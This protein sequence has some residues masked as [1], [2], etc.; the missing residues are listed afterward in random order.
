MNFITKILQILLNIIKKENSEE[1]KLQL[2]DIEKY[3]KP[4]HP[5]YKKCPN[6]NLESHT[7]EEI[8]KDFGLIQMGNYTYIQ[9][10]C[11]KCRK[12]NTPREKNNKENM[13]LFN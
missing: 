6:C 12:G 1:K 10:W 2:F 11:R 5:N 9:S 7:N 4:K 13:N 8:Q 3:K